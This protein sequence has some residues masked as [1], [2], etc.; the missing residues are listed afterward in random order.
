M[1]ASNDTTPANHPLSLYLAN[2]IK[3]IATSKRA[4]PTNDIYIFSIACDTIYPPL[5]YNSSLQHVL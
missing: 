4:I 5:E 3:P 2:K 1:Y